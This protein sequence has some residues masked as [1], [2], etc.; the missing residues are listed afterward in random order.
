MDWTQCLYHY[1]G[2]CV[3]VVDGDTLDL[4]LDLGCF[5]SR[6]VR[7][8]LL[9][10]D[11]PELHDPDPDVRLDAQRA[12]ATIIAETAAR[13]LY[14]RTELDTGDKYGRLL[15]TIYTSVGADKSLNRHMVEWGLAKPYVGWER[16]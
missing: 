7:C 9:G 10:I 14:V 15:V 12:A 3:H 2:R 11:T 1:T 4:L 6:K 8:R 5:V 13:P 16:V